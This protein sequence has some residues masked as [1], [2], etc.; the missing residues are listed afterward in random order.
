MSVTD[1][2]VQ[3]PSAPIVSWPRESPFA[4]ELQTLGASAPQHTYGAAS[5]QVY[6]DGQVA[7]NTH[8]SADGF[9]AYVNQFEQ[10]SFRVKDLQVQWWQYDPPYDDW[11]NNYGCDSVEVFYHAG[12]GGNDAGTGNYSAPLGAAWDNVTFLNSSQMAIG[13]QRLRYLF[14]ATCDGCMVFAPNNPMRTWNVCNRGFRMLFGATGLINDDPNYGTNFWNHW[15]SG[16]SFSQAWQDS[17]LDANSNQQPASTAVGSSAADAQNRL[18]NERFFTNATASR[19]WYW[20]RWV[21]NAPAA[22]NARIVSRMP[23]AIK[24]A[25]VAPRAAS[26]ATVLAS[27]KRLRFEAPSILPDGPFESLRVTSGNTRFAVIPGGAAVEWAPATL[28]RS[29]LTEAQVLNAAKSAIGDI[30]GLSVVAVLP[31]LHA[32]GP[33]NGGP[34]GQ[35]PETFEHIAIYR[36]VVAGLPVLTPG[37][38]EVRVHVAASGQV[39]RI[40]DTRLEIGELRDSGPFAIEAPA[41]ATGT[42]RAKALT[43][44]QDVLAALRQEASRF[45]GGTDGSSTLIPDSIEFGYALRGT[46]LVPIARATVEIGKGQYKMREVV[47]ADLIR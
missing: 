36:Q 41:P 5:M 40:L 39:R 3:R 42:V 21:G 14:L 7:Y 22:A 12:H 27:M 34:G 45:S 4:P 8:A 20:W 37:A 38:G 18:F 26:R 9:L 30:Q 32:G 47:E 19:D 13:D 11:Q 2:I 1:T 28:T 44:T 43:A 6:A 33:V 46:D 15:N 16:V 25:R 24:F 35:E 23:A 31:A 29:N 17:L 10:T